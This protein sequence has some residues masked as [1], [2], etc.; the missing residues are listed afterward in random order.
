MDST[1][2]FPSYSLI[3]ESQ[4][5]ASR[6]VYMHDTDAGASMAKVSYDRAC[7][8]ILGR[9]NLTRDASLEKAYE[10][11][12]ESY[13][14]VNE[15]NQLT[16]KDQADIHIIIALF[17]LGHYSKENGDKFCPLEEEKAYLHLMAA[18]HEQAFN[19]LSFAQQALAHYHLGVL[20]NTQANIGVIRPAGLGTRWDNIYNPDKAYKHYSLCMLGNN[21]E[22]F[23]VLDL[24]YK[25]EVA[26][27]LATAHQLTEEALRTEKYQTCIKTLLEIK[28][29][30]LFSSLENLK[31]A[32]LLITL[33]LHFYRCTLLGNPDPEHISNALLYAVQAQNNPEY[34]NLPRYLQKDLE[35]YLEQSLTPTPETLEHTEESTSNI[36]NSIEEDIQDVLKALEGAQNLDAKTPLIAKL[37]K[38]A[39][40]NQLDNVC[41]SLKTRT[42][43]ELAK[44]FIAI[45]NEGHL[46][47]K[48][49]TKKLQYI[50]FCQH[51]Q[52][53]K[54][55]PQ[56][57]RDLIKTHFD[58]TMETLRAHNQENL[59]IIEALRNSHEFPLEQ[60]EAN[61]PNE[62]ATEESP[63][64]SHS[65]TSTTPSPLENKNNTSS[66]KRQSP[67]ADNPR[68]LKKRVL[69]DY[70]QKAALQKSEINETEEQLDAPKEP[71]T[72]ILTLKELNKLISKE[73]TLEN[74]EKLI[75]IDQDESLAKQVPT[76]VSKNKKILYHL[77]LAECYLGEADDDIKFNYLKC[78][79]HLNALSLKD[80]TQA[81]SKS[82]YYFF[83]IKAN[84]RE[85]PEGHKRDNKRLIQELWSQ[86]T[87]FNNLTIPQREYI[88]G[89]KRNLGI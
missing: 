8:Y 34:K 4:D 11:I 26:Y 84:D 36:L 7:S 86:Q 33:A 59:A 42:L 87:V 77:I 62:V 48:E 1:K 17:Y 81:Y 67:T 9:N 76:L 73:T 27:T 89:L 69:E 72:R 80:L 40:G 21:G 46:T 70:M 47:N 75:E 51:S 44:H 35:D 19:Q 50:L 65:E 3:I 10:K 78:K 57:D 23:R 64:Q 31:Q 2:N 13:N 39:A 61:L 83:S 43:A 22:G 16:S 79:Q 49:T 41:L 37:E 54:S 20:Y 52:G 18:I 29:N 32:Q 38:L 74:L 63:A 6:R 56:V 12:I 14:N 28:Q 45:S 55:L 82:R 58:V 25:I 24:Q 60:N 30:D 88:Q 71:Q 15:F 5:I 66:P 85:K 68:P 53:F